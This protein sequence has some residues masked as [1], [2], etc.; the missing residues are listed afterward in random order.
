MTLPS[1]ESERLIFVAS[2]SRSPVAPV[3]PWRSLP[4]KSTKFNIEL[5]EPDP[6]LLRGNDDSER[7]DEGEREGGRGREEEEEKERGKKRKRFSVNREKIE[8]YLQFLTHSHTGETR[9]FNFRIRKY[10]EVGPFCEHYM[11]EFDN[12]AKV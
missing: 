9:S 6:P 4:A 1:A 3:F 5:R 10:A 7:G 12:N 8:D 11:G 2:F